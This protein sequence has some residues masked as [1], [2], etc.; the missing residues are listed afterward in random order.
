MPW[1]SGPPLWGHLSSMAKILSSALRN[2][3]MS[4]RGVRT[5]RAPT[6]GMSSMRPISIRSLIQP[7][8]MSHHLLHGHKLMGVL[9][10]RG[11]LGPG[12]F[13]GKLLRCQK[14]LVHPAP[15]LRAFHDALLH[16]GQA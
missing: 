1:E 6:C 10:L 3:A 11:T 16:V 7:P 14:T 9:T 8:F 4:P 13:L 15:A 12:V 2:T 5:T